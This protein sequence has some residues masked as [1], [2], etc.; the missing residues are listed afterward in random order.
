LCCVFYGIIVICK[1]HMVCINV[2]A[3]PWEVYKVFVNAT[4][5]TF[6]NKK[7]KQNT[8]FKF[9]IIMVKVIEISAFRIP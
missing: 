2:M 8:V 4:K 3:I 5:K 6:T 9:E 7:C 1:N